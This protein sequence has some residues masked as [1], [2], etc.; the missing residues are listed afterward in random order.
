MRGRYRFLKA[1]NNYARAY[2]ELIE[3]LSP[4]PQYVGLSRDPEMKVC[5]KIHVRVLL[6]TNV[7]ILIDFT[8]PIKD[9]Y[10]SEY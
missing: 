6:F 2:K 4:L 3:G 5:K 7:K 1:F 8:A 10:N 9:Y